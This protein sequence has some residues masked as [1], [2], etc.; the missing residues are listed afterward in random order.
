MQDNSTLQTVTVNGHEFWE[1][2]AVAQRLAIEGNRLIAQ[3]IA[4]GIRGLWPRVVRLLDA[5]QRW[6]LPP[7]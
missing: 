1:D 3:E 7:I 4:K 5:G 2:C 6:H